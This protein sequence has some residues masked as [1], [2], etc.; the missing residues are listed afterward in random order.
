[1]TKDRTSTLFFE[2]LQIAMHNRQSLSIVPSAEEWQ[3][4]YDL[5]VKQAL[6]GVVYV[7]LEHLKGEYSPSH[8]MLLNWTTQ[9][10]VI[11]NKNAK[12]TELCEALVNRFKRDGVT[13]C[14]LKGQG[15]LINYP[16]WLKHSRTTGDVD[17]WTSGT[18]PEIV[19]FVYKHTK[20]SEGIRYN[21]IDF[22]IVPGYEV[23]MHFHPS[24]M[25]NFI[26][27]HRL[28]KW[29]NDVM[30]AHQWQEYNG[31]CIPSIDFNVVY[32]LS[33]MYTH[34][35]DE[36]VGLRQMVDYYYVLKSYHE[37][38]EGSDGHQTLYSSHKD[39]VQRISYFGMNK[40]AS[41]VMYVLKEVF[42]M[43]DEYIILPPNEK[44]GKFL[45]SEMLRAGHFGHFD[46]RH[47]HKGRTS[48]EQAW[49]K[50]KRNLSLSS[51][52]PA[53]ALSEPFFRLY[54]WCWR[55]RM[56]RRCSVKAQ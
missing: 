28:Q 55:Q 12:L 3:A 19:A 56:I 2:L 18:I 24:F 51:H 35:F 9:Y 14:V 52:Y 46:D 54:H 4:L 5:S 17:M 39:V 16:E 27:N 20:P 41:S 10:N 25:N 33:H 11:S 7:A 50:L 22:P 6:G 49:I 43:P 13:S 37:A 53:E 8:Q 21:H 26:Y 40:F 42:A 45:L 23:E 32:Q 31:F 15:N 34:L 47:K 30:E 48:A 44:E 36:G 29:Y 38:L 1:M